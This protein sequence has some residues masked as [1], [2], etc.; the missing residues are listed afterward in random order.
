[1][2]LQLIIIAL[3]AIQ[4]VLGQ[5]RKLSINVTSDNKLTI[6]V[7]GEEWFHSSPVKVRNNGSWL[8]T[9]DGSLILG[10]SFVNANSEDRLGVYD[11]YEFSY[12][13]SSKEFSFTTFVRDYKNGNIVYGQRFDSG[14]VKTAVDSADDVISSFPSI[15]LEDSSLERGYVIFE[16]SSKCQ[17]T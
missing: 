17:N 16:G 4:V 1:M 10:N 12:H 13:D 7:N 11:Y 3:F 2:Q 14:A 8:S 5:E 9:T 15:T 6:S